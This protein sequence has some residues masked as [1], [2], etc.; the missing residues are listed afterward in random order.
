MGFWDICYLFL[1]LTYVFGNPKPYSTIRRSKLESLNAFLYIE[2][3]SAL[4]V[5]EWKLIFKSW[6]EW[7][8]DYIFYE[9]WNLSLNAI[10]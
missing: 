4:E 1:A 2:Q 3:S 7:A 10:N 6:M 8:G 5:M 9:Y